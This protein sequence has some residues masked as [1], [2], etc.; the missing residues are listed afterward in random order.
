MNFGIAKVN[1]FLKILIHWNSLL[2]GV[3]IIDNVSIITIKTTQA[4]STN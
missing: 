4:I 2:Q 3:Q 1:P